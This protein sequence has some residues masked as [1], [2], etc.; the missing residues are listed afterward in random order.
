MQQFCIKHIA[1][2]F[3]TRSPVSAADIDGQ[4]ARELMAPLLGQDE[5]LQG[6]IS[7]LAEDLFGDSH[8]SISSETLTPPT[9]KNM[10][11]A[12]SSRLKILPRT[13]LVYS[14]SSAAKAGES[15]RRCFA[16]F[17]PTLSGVLSLVPPAN[18]LLRQ[19]AR[20]LGQD[21]RTA[22]RS[23]RDDHLLF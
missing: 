18:R 19:R 4:R 10:Q 11:A 23:S 9:Y 3:R 8:P 16:S 7:D 15:W 1:K 21:R 13:V 22:R 6:L 2:Y 5:D 12:F 14:P 20:R 17:E